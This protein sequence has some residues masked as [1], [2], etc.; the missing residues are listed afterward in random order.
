[1]ATKQFKDVN[2]NEVFTLNG[3]NYTKIEEVRVSCCRCINA[4]LTTD[5]NNKIQVKPLDEV[6]VSDEQK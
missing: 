5:P 3:V 4:C 1:M 6:V 2:V